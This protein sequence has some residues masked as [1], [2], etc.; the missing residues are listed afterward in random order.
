MPKN[1]PISNCQRKEIKLKEFEI[2]RWNKYQFSDLTV[3]LLCEIIMGLNFR[4]KI[5]LLRR[6]KT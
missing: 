5:E 2:S 3:R 4:A 1:L 6:K